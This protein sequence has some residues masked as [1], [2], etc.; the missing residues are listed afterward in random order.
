MPVIAA[1]FHAG[2]VTGQLV[3]DRRPPPRAAEF[4]ASHL[5]PPLS[6]MTR[7]LIRTEAFAAGSISFLKRRVPYFMQP[8]S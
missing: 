6:G 1:A 7:G 4:S 5:P 3:C 2:N 8:N